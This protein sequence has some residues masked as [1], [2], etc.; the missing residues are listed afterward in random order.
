METTAVIAAINQSGGVIFWKDYGKSVDIPKF[1]SFLKELR[2]IKKKDEFSIFMDNLAVHRSHI[3]R[4]V[5]KQLKINRIFN[6][7]YSP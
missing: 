7:P 6:A 3:V 4:D 2:K 1:I 5:M